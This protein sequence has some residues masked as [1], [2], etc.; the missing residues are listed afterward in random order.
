M[1]NFILIIFTIASFTALGKTDTSSFDIL[2]IKTGMNENEVATILDKICVTPKNRVNGI[3]KNNELNT[4][5]TN[6]LPYDIYFYCD[7]S[8]EKGAA[9]ADFISIKIGNNK[10]MA[11]DAF[12]SHPEYYN[13]PLLP[14]DTIM[15]ANNI[16]NKKTL[17]KYGEPDISYISQKKENTGT[18][19]GYC[20]DDDTCLDGNQ[21]IVN[22][23]GNCT[24]RTSMFL[25]NKI[26][27][28]VLNGSGMIINLRSHLSQIPQSV[29]KLRDANIIEDFKKKG[30]NL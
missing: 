14:W 20:I 21:D 2:G 15:Q 19:V 9:G 10:V 27:E 22:C 11:I 29:F 25:K 16:L 3:R 7:I 24:T 30:S 6:T 17:N 5:E 4:D 1:K 18:F 8:E 28:I 26:Q 23:W 13:E 12:L